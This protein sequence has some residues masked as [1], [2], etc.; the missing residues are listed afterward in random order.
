MRE[1]EDKLIKVIPKE[2]ILDAHHWLILH[3]RYICKAQKPLCHQCIV[4]DLCEYKDK[5]IE[6]AV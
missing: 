4:N 2:F 1:V 3:G 6:Q 5:T